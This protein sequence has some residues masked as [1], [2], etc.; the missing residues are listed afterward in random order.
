MTLDG[1][2][3]HSGGLDVLAQ[4]ILGMACSA[5]F[6]PNALY[7]EICRAAPYAALS[8]PDFDDIVNFIATGGYTLGNYERYHRLT[9]LE[10]GRYTISNPSVARLWRMNVGTIVSGVTMRVKM[11]RGPVLGEVEEHFVQ[12]L[13]PGDTFIFAGRLLKFEA[14][15]QLVVECTKGGDGDPKIPAYAGSRMPLTTHLAGR[16][17][18]LL[19]EPRRWN[20]LPYDVHEWLLLQQRRSSLP[21]PDQ[22]LVETFPRGKRHFLVAYSFEGR[23]A[24]QTLGMLITRRMERMGLKPLGFVATDYVLS[25]WSLHAP[26]TETIAA[27]FGQDMLGDDLE[28]WMD[29]SSML[30]R[31]FRNVAVI[32]GLIE[33]RH[34]G[35]EK[36]AGK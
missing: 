8:R 4:H 19:S 6:D 11:R 25:V 30:R 31:T 5:P 29:E 28:E 16:V 20:D 33:R 32:A 35:H 18:G 1:D 13:V 9:K 26:D 3:P 17:R 7:A 22:L 14:V 12:G 34:P 27:L 21:T 2:P 36:T 23:N 10:D 24:H 15:R